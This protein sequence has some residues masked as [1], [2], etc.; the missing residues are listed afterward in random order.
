[1][2]PRSTATASGLADLRRDHP[3]FYWVW[4]R[5]IAASALLPWR[6]ARQLHGVVAACERGRIARTEG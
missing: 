1:M 2:T 5:V 4:R 6:C 3:L